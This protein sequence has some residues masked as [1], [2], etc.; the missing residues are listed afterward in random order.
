MPYRLNPRQKRTITCCL[1]L[2]AGLVLAFIVLN[3]GYPLAIDEKKYST[4]VT[5]RDG[6]PLRA[7]TDNEGIWRYPVELNAVSPLYI[8]AL[9]NYED[10]WFYYHPGINPASFIRAALQNVKSG[11]IVSGGSTLTMQVAR[12]LHP[13]KRNLTGKMIQ[14]FRALQLEYHLSKTDILNLYINLAPF[15]SNIEGSQTA[16]FAYLGKS[17]SSLSH[18]EAALLAVLPQAPSFYR[19]DRHPERARKARNK[20]LDRLEKFRIWDSDTIREAKNEPLI[21]SRFFQPMTAPLLSRRL[22][23][24][25]KTK[26]KIQTTIDFDLQVHMEDLA[27]DYVSELSDDQSAAIMVVNHKTLETL[28]Y[29][30]SAEFR[31]NKRKG[32]VDMIAAV[33]SPGSA[34]KPFLYGLAMDDGLI[35]SHSLLLDTPR[36]QQ[37]YDPGNFTKGFTG[38]VSVSKALRMS[39]NVPAV[40]V[41]EAYGPHKFNDRLINAGARLTLPGNPNLSMILGGVGISLESMISLY[42]GLAREGLSAKPKLQSDDPVVER[43]LMSEGAAWIVGQILLQPMPGFDRINRLVKETPMAWKTGTSYGFRDAWS[44]GIMGDYVAGVWVGNPDGSPSP[45][46]YGAVTA[47]PLLKQVIESLPQPEFKFDQPESV[48]RQKICWPLGTAQ[49]ALSK[50]RNRDCYRF[51]SAFILDHHFPV[52]LMSDNSKF[53]PLL[54]TFWIDQQGFRATP[55]CGGVKRV[56]KAVWPLEAEPFIPRSQRRSALIPKASKHCPDLAGFESHGLQITSA[57]N[58][59][60]I[61]VPPGESNLP[62]IELRARG[63]QG[64]YHWFLNGKPIRKTPHGQ[65]GFMTFP[66]AG[67]YQLAVVDL[68]GNFDLVEFEVIQK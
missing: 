29:V 44:F 24:L 47:L 49:S 46:Q 41:L 4:V 21:A 31:N 38:P 68:Q 65:T 5:A 17:V 45:G 3:F 52:T 9:L 55:S 28:A 50:S 26:K 56:T 66:K 1:S 42:T 11:R 54:K 12:M 37:D 64:D 14:I 33:R 2:L 27:L 40:Q 7:F 57:S 36:F 43:R 19:P 13:G 22:Y 39:L 23:H 32:H 20:V 58:N 34:L 61:A 53:N 15:G 59:S 30:G 8:E 60:K 10:R 48:T 18:A 63:G 25:D 35:H 62:N 51:H 67:V 16:A 6:T